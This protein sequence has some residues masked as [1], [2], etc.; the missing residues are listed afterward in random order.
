[1]EK[2]LEENYAGR[3]ITIYAHTYI[4]PVYSGTEQ[5]VEF[6]GR[7]GTR[8]VYGGKLDLAGLLQKMKSDIDGGR[9]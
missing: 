3:L 6:I 1:M 8:E 7:M 4:P 2:V 9:L 5:A